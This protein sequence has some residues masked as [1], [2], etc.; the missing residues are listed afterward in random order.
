MSKKQIWS[1]VGIGLVVAAT[2]IGYKKY[3]EAEPVIAL[4]QIKEAYDTHDIRLFKKHVAASAVIN[5]AMD[6]VIKQKM[7][8]AGD[9][10]MVNTGWSV[11][12]DLI[13]LIKPRISETIENQIYQAIETGQLKFENSGDMAVT[14]LKKAS[15]PFLDGEYR[16]DKI[17]A[18]QR[19]GNEAR[20]T[21]KFASDTAS[22]P[23]FLKCKLEKIDGDWKLTEILN[24]AD[25][26]K[27]AERR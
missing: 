20:V 26:M 6:Q 2:W 24:A 21:L 27:L 23:F 9:N 4:W 13:M 11:A 19:E 7:P 12:S 10:P 14:S 25:W 8:T 5:S 3:R 18:I 1:I 15:E 22:K 16:F 17:E